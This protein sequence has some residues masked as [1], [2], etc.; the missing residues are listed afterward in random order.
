MAWRGK[1]ER[2][3]D[4]KI[5]ALSREIEALKEQRIINP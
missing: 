1:S 2:S 5:E 3:Q 4:E